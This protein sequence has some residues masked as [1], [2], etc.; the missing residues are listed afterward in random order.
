M[1]IVHSKSHLL[2]ANDPDLDRAPRTTKTTLAG[3]ATAVTRP[4]ISSPLAN[5]GGLFAGS[6]RTA[7][8]VG[9]PPAASQLRRGPAPKPKAG[10]L[11]R[12]V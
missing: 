12:T 11:A 7:W 8:S 2:P 9:W 10:S 1:V 6:M 3:F 4:A 5:A